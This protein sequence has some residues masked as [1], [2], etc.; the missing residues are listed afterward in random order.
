MKKYSTKEQV[1]L[2]TLMRTLYA[3]PLEVPR[4]QRRWVFKALRDAVDQGCFD[5]DN[6]GIK[7]FHRHLLTAIAA[8]EELGLKETCVLAILLYRPALK[9]CIS[10]AEVRRVLGEE[11]ARILELLLKTSDLYARNI[12]VSSD[13]FRNLLLSFAEDIRVILIIIADRLVLLRLAN[14]MTDKEHQRALATEVS[15]LYAPLAHRLG[16]YAIK[17]EMEDLCLKYSDRKTF[18]FIKRKLNETKASRDRYIE[19]FIEPVRKRLLEE[20][21][22]FQIK[23]R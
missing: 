18:D 11:V 8:A 1:Q 4:E 13:N 5:V 22:R 16:L 10:V 6:Y 19:Q 2:I 17:G 9:E 14:K 21:L 23:G 3:Q 15:F 12:T 7:G 20:G